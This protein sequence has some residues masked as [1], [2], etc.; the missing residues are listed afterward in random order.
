MNCVIL[1]SLEFEEKEEIDIEGSI[2]QENWRINFNFK[3]DMT[4]YLETKY[5]IFN[6]TVGD[7]FEICGQIILKSMLWWNGRVC[8]KIPGAINISSA[9]KYLGRNWR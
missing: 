5:I 9:D 3:G 1:K 8:C 7:G 2:N 6:Q 4:K